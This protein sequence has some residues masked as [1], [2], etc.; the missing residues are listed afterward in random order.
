MEI[1]GTR[2]RNAH[3]L[4][5]AGANVRLRRKPGLLVQL[6]KVQATVLLCGLHKLLQAQAHRLVLSTAKDKQPKGLHKGVQC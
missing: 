2:Q 1:A 6:V 4:L 5:R 3:R